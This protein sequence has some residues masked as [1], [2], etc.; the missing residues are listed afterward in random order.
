MQLDRILSPGNE[1][2]VKN[3]INGFITFIDDIVDGAILVPVPAA[4]ERR[5]LVKPGER[6]LIS[7]VTDLGLYM[8]ETEVGEVSLSDNVTMAEL[9]V[10]SNYKKIQRR[11]AFRANE[12][13]AVSVRRKE[14]EGEAPYPWVNTQTVDLSE[15]G[16][17]LKYNEPCEPGWT[18]E[19]VLHL[20]KYGVK[21]TLPRIVCSVAR[22]VKTDSRQFEYLIGMRFEE[23]NEKTQDTLIKFVV[24]SQRSKLT[25]KQGKGY[26]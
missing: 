21:E 9:R 18:M 17:L 3:E 15:T 23:M 10:I 19:L 26:K 12:C 22:C 24:L 11:D 8:M 16:V 7:C 4:G 5:V 25:Y 2:R 20:D 6:Y 13:I 14:R 1:V